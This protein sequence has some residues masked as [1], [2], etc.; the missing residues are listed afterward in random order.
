MIASGWVWSTCGAGTKA[1]SSVSIDGR[2]WSGDS[3]QRRRWST[4][5]ASSMLSRSRRGRISSRRSAAKPAAGIVARSVPDPLTHRA[6][7]SR[8]VWSATRPLAEVLPPPTL[9]SARSAPSRWER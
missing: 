9:A 6:W 3:P 8:P 7:T 4:I 5:A 2:G 1:C